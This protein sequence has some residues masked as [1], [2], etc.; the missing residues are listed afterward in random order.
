VLAKASKIIPVMIMGKVV[1]GRKYEYYEYVVALLIS[2]GMSLFLFGSSQGRDSTIH[3]FYD[4]PDKE[5]C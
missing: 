2:L 5:S 3:Q 4:I 1:S